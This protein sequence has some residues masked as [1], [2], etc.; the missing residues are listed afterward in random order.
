M[1]YFNQQKSIN[2]SVKNLFIENGI[3][4]ERI[5]AI[6]KGESRQASILEK[7]EEGQFNNNMRV[8][9]TIIKY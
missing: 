2:Q 3:A 1:I 8:E 9:I 7:D 5:K 6:G 4:Q